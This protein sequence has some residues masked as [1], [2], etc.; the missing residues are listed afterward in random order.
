MVVVVVVTV[1]VLVV[2]IVVLVVVVVFWRI[3]D[4]QIINKLSNL[5][6]DDAIHR[7]KA[8]A[9][10]GSIV[11]VVVVVVVVVVVLVVVVVFRRIRDHQVICYLSNLIRDDTIYR[12]KTLAIQGSSSSRSG[13]GCGGSSCCCRRRCL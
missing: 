8:L 2:V 4:H 9:I 7:V 1:V 5:I 11:L 13:G 6:R 3:R 10:Q 12:A